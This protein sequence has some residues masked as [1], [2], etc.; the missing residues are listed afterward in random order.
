MQ[1]VVSN[2][3]KDHKEIFYIHSIGENQEVQSHQTSGEE[4]TLLVGVQHSKSIWE[5]NWQYLLGIG[6]QTLKQKAGVLSKIN[7]HCLQGTDR[8]QC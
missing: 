7:G 8:R 6:C 5:T 2:A 4:N 1:L 3:N